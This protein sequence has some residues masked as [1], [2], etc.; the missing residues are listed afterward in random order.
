MKCSNPLFLK[1]GSRDIQVPW[2][3]ARGAREKSLNQ[4]TASLPSMIH[5]PELLTIAPCTSYVYLE[6]AKLAVILFAI[7]KSSY[8][9]IILHA[10]DLRNHEGVLKIFSYK[11]SLVTKV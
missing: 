5:W 3:S 11:G 1:V 2:Q 10:C 4:I 7:C 6:L 9:H 8:S